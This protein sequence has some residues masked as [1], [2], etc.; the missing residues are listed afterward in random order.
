MKLKK[1]YCILL[2]ILIAGICGMTTVSA[3][4]S[5]NKS[6]ELYAGQAAADKG[7]EI[8]LPVSVSGNPGIATVR[9][10]VEYDT[11]I[12]SLVTEDEEGNSVNAIE[13]G[14]VLDSGNL[15]SKETEKGCQILW[16]NET[17]KKT[18]GTLFLIH[19]KI[20]E[21]AEYAKYPVNIS[22]YPKDTGNEKETLVEFICQ[23]GTIAVES[24]APA[25]Y[26]GTVRIEAGQTVDFPV[27]IKNNPGVSGIMVYVATGDSKLQVVKDD[28]GEIIAER[29]N[30][31][32]KGTVL[33]ND[34]RS[35]WKVLWYTTEGDQY[36]DGSIFT[37]R[38]KA[39]ED[40]KAGDIPVTVT[41]MPENTVDSEGNKVSISSSA[42]GTIKVRTTIY[43][44]I[45]DNM[46][47]DLA[48][49]LYLKRCLAGWDGYSII[50]SA[51]ADLN[52]DDNV[53]IEDVTILER[54][55]AG[56]NGY[57]SLPK[58]KQN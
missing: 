22:Y 50:D 51:A 1:L 48:D 39:S 5:G 37:L 41:C 43:G 45:D 29:G 19:L 14:D 32:E 16:V 15:Y 49:A 27:Y 33:A 24:A 12:F 3:A 56:W 42:K 47:V 18:D 54:H 25:I 20:S 4:D 36:S 58:S 38:L 8:I 52:G 53:T 21:D 6:P 44:D 11:E 35:G 9:L 30:F 55:I 23:N 57:D 13:K 7:Q 28:E 17:D 40:I 2:A 26:G 46:T 10:D 34:Y 31:S